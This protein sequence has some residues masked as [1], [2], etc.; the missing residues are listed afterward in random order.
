MEEKNQEKI[1]ALEASI[2]TMREQ[3][4]LARAEIERLQTAIKDHQLQGMFFFSELAVDYFLKTI[5]FQDFALLS[6]FCLLAGVEE[7]NQKK[8]Q[9]LE[10]SISSMREQYN[11]A[12]AEIGRLQNAIKDHHLQGIIFQN[13]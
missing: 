13:W 8:I 5:L 2:S 1:Q 7:K 3:N 4:K 11:L 12:R 6:C 9:A 10:A